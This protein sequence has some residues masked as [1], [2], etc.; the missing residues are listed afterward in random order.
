MF[1]CCRP[2]TANQVV[3]GS[4]SSQPLV[5]PGWGALVGENTDPNGFAQVVGHWEHG[6]MLTIDDG[7]LPARKVGKLC[8]FS[9]RAA[10]NQTSGRFCSIALLRQRD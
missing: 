6:G 9:I 2:T 8:V 1:S 3:T 5:F 4:I 7:H 10:D